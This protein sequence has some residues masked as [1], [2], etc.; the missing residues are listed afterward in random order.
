MEFFEALKIFENLIV[1]DVE[2]WKLFKNIRIEKFL[3]IFEG[4]NIHS[5]ALK[6]FKGIDICSGA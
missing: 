1:D 4:G 5:K 2:A 6:I 3:K